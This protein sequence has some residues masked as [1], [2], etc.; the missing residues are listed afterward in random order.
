MIPRYTRSEM[1]KIWTE[2]RKYETW[3]EIELA[4][5]DALSELGEIPTEAVREIREKA[6]FDASRIDEIEK[7]TK[8]DVLAFLTN[9]GESIGPLSKYLHYGLTSSD[10]LDTSHIGEEGNDIVFGHLLDLV[11]SFGIEPCLFADFAHGLPRNLA[12]F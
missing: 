8:H 6:C 9:V 7:V 2:Q 5:C 1:A 3:L 10:I 4:V 12:K 11:D